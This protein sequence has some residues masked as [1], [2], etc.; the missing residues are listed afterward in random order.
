MQEDNNKY[1][2]EDD[3]L[4]R[5]VSSNANTSSQ[6]VIFTNAQNEL[7]G[8]NVAKVEELIMNKGISITKDAQQNIDSSSLGVS[9]IRGNLV[10]MINFDDWLGNK[11]YT[12]EDL[13]LIILTNYSNARLGMIIKSVV[14]IQ[15]FEAENF[16]KSDRD[17]KTTFIVETNMNGEKRLCKI[18][19][20]DRL[21]M[22]IF[23]KSED[24]YREDVDKIDKNH[25]QRFTDKMILF[26]EDSILIQKHMRNLLDNFEYRYEVFENGKGLLDRLNNIDLDDIGLIIT[27]IEMPVM[28][29]ITMMKEI[30][31]NE[32]YSQ[33]PI[34]VNTNMANNAI[35]SSS[36]EYGAKDVVK[37]LDM[38]ALFD[39]I[40]NYTR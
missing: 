20:S 8:I 24:K 21:L 31:K 25:N 38:Q 22:D 4:I 17:E 36:M 28:D 29:G 15:S 3:E 26:A 2:L 12:D 5:L 9:K 39:A 32:K 10:T 1:D 11:D 34:V 16:N 40:K 30:Q 14:G 19:D 35:I 18:F 6:Y 23:N 13:R 7:Y 37:K 33:I 27:D